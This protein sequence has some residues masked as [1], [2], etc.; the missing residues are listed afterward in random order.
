[1][2]DPIATAR[3]AGRTL[4]TEV[5]SKELLHNAGVN[6]TQARLATSADEA[7]ATTID[8][9]S[10]AHLGLAAERIHAGG[11]YP[12][13]LTIADMARKETRLIASNAARWI[14]YPTAQLALGDRNWSIPLIV[15]PFALAALGVLAMLGLRWIRRA[16]QRS[17]VRTSSRTGSPR[18]SSPSAAS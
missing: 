10:L 2:S 14:E 5:E 16:D 9:W 8:R 17:L 7:V 18:R 13:D 15:R 1:M 12:Y 3:A 4:L 11:G 6:V